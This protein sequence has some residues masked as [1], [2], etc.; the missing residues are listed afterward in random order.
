M[1]KCLPYVVFGLFLFS[2]VNCT[3]SSDDDYIYETD[4]YSLVLPTDWVSTT[5]EKNIDLIQQRSV[6]KMNWNGFI[7]TESTDLPCSVGLIIEVYLV[8]NQSILEVD[9]A[10][11]KKFFTSWK[12]QEEYENYVLDSLTLCGREM[13][14]CSFENPL[15][16]WPNG[17]ET[18]T[19][20]SFY[21]WYESDMIFSVQYVACEDFELYRDSALQIICSLKLN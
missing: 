11:K 2:L 19:K 1:N 5:P 20:Y 14:F 7:N 4:L 13:L 12:D 17:T 6:S 3:E 10:L 18:F 21:K 15:H 9:D 16:V 8:D